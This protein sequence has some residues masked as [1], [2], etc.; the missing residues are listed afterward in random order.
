MFSIGKSSKLLIANMLY[1][2]YRRVGLPVGTSAFA[3][4][5]T[6]LERLVFAHGVGE[7]LIVL[8]LWQ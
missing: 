4:F 2:F 6:C 5:R 8:F 3:C 7:R 1:P